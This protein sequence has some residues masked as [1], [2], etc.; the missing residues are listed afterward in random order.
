MFGSMQ[1]PESFYY[2]SDYS[3]DYSDCE[4]KHKDYEHDCMSSEGEEENDISPENMK[5]DEP[6]PI[7]DETIPIKD[8]T[9]PDESE[10]EEKETEAD[11]KTCSGCGK[12]HHIRNF[13]SLM[14]GT[15]TRRCIT[16]RLKSN[17]YNREGLLKEAD[18]ILRAAM[19]ACVMCGD[20]DPDHLEHNHM[21]PSNK[22]G[23]VGNMTTV[24]KKLTESK[25]CKPY[26]RKCHCKH[27]FENEQCGKR[28]TE[29]T[30][31]KHRARNRAREFIIN[32][33]KQ[34]GGCQ[35]PDCC[36]VFDPDNLQFYE[37]D[38]VIFLDK[39]REISDMVA[40]GYSI[41]AI[42]LELVKCILLCGYCHKIK[43]REDV[44]KRQEYYQSLDRPLKRK[45]KQVQKPLL[46]D[47]IV[48]EIRKLYNDNE[49]SITQQELADKFKIKVGTVTKIINNIR[50]KD[51]N[52]KK[53]R[54]VKTLTLE[55][56]KEIRK[57]YHENL[58]TTKEDLAKRFDTDAANIVRVL[59]NQTFYDEKYIRTRQD[60]KTLTRDII[61]EIRDDYNCKRLTRAQL[62]EKHKINFSQLDKILH[63]EE[64]SDVTYIEKEKKTRMTLK[65]A[66]NIRKLFHLNHKTKK[67][68]SQQYNVREHQI[69]N[70]LNNK[71]HYDPKY[72]PPK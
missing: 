71:S 38:H 22:L 17:K 57:T 35:N 58:E 62:T 5:I 56:A 14:N 37:F 24:E 12:E 44:I 2:Y 54:H 51:E 25:K 65:D 41:E 31:D 27:T 3:E 26:C 10:D 50:Y 4:N 8:E 42:K 66:Q 6:I 46:S 18:R 52:Y 34:L 32:L 67:E 28:K 49:S 68:L 47:D 43:T 36:D 11:M 19:G 29:E 40:E 16:C 1:I 60:E 7:K 48:N 53:T 13:I 64:D 59:M 61:R 69:N 72:T 63:S 55:N 9:I 70:I 23:E 15:E 21:D 20:A 30:N 45:E 39:L 33:K